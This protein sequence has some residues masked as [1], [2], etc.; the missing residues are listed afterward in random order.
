MF[1]LALLFSFGFIVVLD[2]FALGLVVVI[3]V[4]SGYVRFSGVELFV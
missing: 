3:I 1:D 4:Y 2:W